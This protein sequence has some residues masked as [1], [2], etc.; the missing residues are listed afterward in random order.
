MA[1]TTGTLTSG[2]YDYTQDEL[3]AQAEAVYNPAYEAT[4]NS[5][6]AQKTSL[7]T[8]KQRTLAD[9][10]DYV[11]KKL[12]STEKTLNDSLIKRGMG[13]S[14]R[15]TYE[16]T[17]GLADVNAEAQESIAEIEQD[18]QSNISNI[19]TQLS[20]AA[21][22]KEQNVSAKL[23]DLMQYYESVRQFEKEYA[24]KEAALNSSGGGG[25]G[26]PN[27]GPV[28]GGDEDTYIN[29][30]T[31]KYYINGKQVTAAEFGSY[32]GSTAARR[33]GTPYTGRSG[34]KYYINGKQV[35]LSQYASRSGSTASRRSGR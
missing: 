9:Y 13:R 31:G 8:T 21:A 26:G 25:G 24:L 15:G 34:N 29:T 23:L 7:A 18:Y 14:D 32:T 16:I 27:T 1:T 19:D 30:T 11:D 28:T 5:L 6:N 33:S 12:K 35:T 22:T 3:R 10:S 2:K 17:Q 20:T 4:V